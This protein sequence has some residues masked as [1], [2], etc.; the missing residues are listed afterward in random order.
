MRTAAAPLEISGLIVAAATPQDPSISVGPVEEVIR[1][2]GSRTVLHLLA[3]VPV[4][5][6]VLTT[7]VG[8]TGSAGGRL[9]F[10]C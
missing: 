3:M 4:V 2:S 8:D 5:L 9:A 10:E 7:E 6:A 1:D